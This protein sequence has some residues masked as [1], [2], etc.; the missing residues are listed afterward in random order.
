[1]DS[2][3]RHHLRSNVVGYI[4][5]FVALTG[6]AVA[7]PGKNSVNSGDIVN[8][9]IKSKDIGEGQIGSREVADDDTS[10]A[11]SS[12]DISNESLSGAD[13]LNGSIT[14]S[15]VA[16][17]S[18][19]GGDI[20]ESTLAQVPSA[21]LGGIGRAF[22]GPSCNPTSETYID[23][24]F[25]TLTLPAPSRVL[26]NAVTR[27]YN[28]SGDNAFGFCRLVTSNGVLAGTNMGGFATNPVPM[29]TVTGVLGAG[30]VDFG[31]ECN[32]VNGDVGFFEVGVSAVALSAN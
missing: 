4:A 18:L 31:I 9:T 15:E 14:S 30:S 20:D 16:D 1:M 29:T 21:A 3:L 25:V 5:L 11:L 17:G 6:T 19:G 7:L 8:S 10:F 26:I 13:I 27:A 2:R 12:E 24:G 28:N 23:C 22:D 32:E